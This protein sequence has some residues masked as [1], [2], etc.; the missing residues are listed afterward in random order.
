VRLLSTNLPQLVKAPEQQNKVSQQKL[1]AE[2]S[3]G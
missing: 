3:A 2:A 1:Q